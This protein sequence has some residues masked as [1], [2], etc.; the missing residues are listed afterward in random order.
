MMGR[1]QAFELDR[2]GARREAGLAGPLMAELCALLSCEAQGTAGVRLVGRPKLADLLSA[3]NAIGAHVAECFGQ[4]ARSVRAVL[5]DK[6]DDCNWALGWHQDRTIAVAARAEADGFGPWPVKQS[7]QHVEPP[8][9]IIAGMITVRIHLD[10][11]DEQNAPLL[12]ALGSH[13]RGRVPA[14][15]VDNVVAQSE[16]H[17]CLARPGDVWLYRTSILHASAR[18]RTP[19]RRRRVL[20]VDYAAQDLPA[21]LEW[22]GI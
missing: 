22:L 11:V 6:S 19:D 8:F 15:E 16:V 14:G 3:S 9:A 12:I 13:R 2:D 5:F 10:P 4:P 20:Q 7:I 21:G 1:E 17:A 18:S